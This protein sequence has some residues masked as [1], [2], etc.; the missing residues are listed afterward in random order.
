M[1]LLLS[2]VIDS[3][4]IDYYD[5]MRLNLSIEKLEKISV[6]I[7]VPYYKKYAKLIGAT[8]FETYDDII[9]NAIRTDFLFEIYEVTDED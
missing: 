2:V 1:K 9:Y 8:R 7:L 3:V 6:E 5:I 4:F